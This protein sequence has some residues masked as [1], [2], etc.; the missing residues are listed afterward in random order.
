MEGEG[1][2]VEDIGEAVA[3]MARG[4]ENE[5]KGRE[6]CCDGEEEDGQEGGTGRR[7]YHGQWGREE[8]TFSAW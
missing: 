4:G 2:G 7:G 3:Y 5:D 8:K 1:D 6:E